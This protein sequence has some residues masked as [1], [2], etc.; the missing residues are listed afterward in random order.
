[1]ARQKQQ[2]ED[3]SPLFPSLLPT[4]AAYVHFL[5]LSLPLS[6]KGH[7]RFIFFMSRRSKSPASGMLCSLQQGKI[8]QDK[9]FGDMRSNL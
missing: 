4:R 6:K 9:S 1:M 2:I 8:S 5:S 7:V 3:L